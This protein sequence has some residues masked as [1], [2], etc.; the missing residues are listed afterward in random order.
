MKQSNGKDP[1]NEQTEEE[2]EVSLTPTEHCT[3]QY[4]ASTQFKKSRAGNEFMSTVKEKVLFD[5]C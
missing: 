5:Y 1:G 2:M 3:Q 4:K